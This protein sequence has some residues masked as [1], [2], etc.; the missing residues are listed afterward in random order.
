MN[1]IDGLENLEYVS[2]IIRPT[3]NNMHEY[4]EVMMVFANSYI[5]NR[6]MELPECLLRFYD[7]TNANTDHDKVS[8]IIKFIKS[9]SAKYVMYKTQKSKPPV[10]SIFDSVYTHFT[11]PIR[12]YSD[13]IVH[14]LVNQL[15]CPSGYKVKD[16]CDPLNNI[17]KNIKK[18]E[19]LSNILSLCYKLS[20][21]GETISECDASI[22]SIRKNSVTLYI[23][24]FDVIAKCQLYSMYL[25]H[26]FDI[27]LTENS[28]SIVPKTI[29]DDI[30]NESVILK[31]GSNVTVKIVIT[32][33]SPTIKNKFLVQI[34]NPDMS[35]IFEKKAS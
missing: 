9:D 5:A 7:G 23:H 21:S 19:R 12:R 33:S 20:D 32:L 18:A 26:C 15:I 30:I 1:L 17:Q 27:E 28:I 35:Q 24:K 31:L 3:S 10:H 29:C 22:V 16:I 13:I 14:R 34:I 6:I 4:V 8:N 25:E 2:K 11:S